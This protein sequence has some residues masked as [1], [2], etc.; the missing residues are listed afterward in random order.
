M[1]WCAC[2]FA[3]KCDDDDEEEEED[4]DPDAGLTAPPDK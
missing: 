2:E 1:I 4:V 3:P